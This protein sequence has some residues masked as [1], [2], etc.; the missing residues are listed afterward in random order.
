[1]PGLDR[2]TATKQALYAHVARLLNRGES[3]EAVHS[4]M[5]AHGFPEQTASAVVQEVAAER[6]VYIQAAQ[7]LGSGVSPEETH[8]RIVRDGLD[9]QTAAAIVDDAFQ[10]RQQ[11]LQEQNRSAGTMVLGVLLFLGGI[12]LFIGNT[13][14]LFPTFPFAGFLLMTIG[15]AVC[16]AAQ[17]AG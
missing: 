9:R 4:K 13:T 8:A 16:A 2:A 7:L 15:G 12:A 14:G 6:A 11:A 1:M 17:R 10:A 5:L 3:P